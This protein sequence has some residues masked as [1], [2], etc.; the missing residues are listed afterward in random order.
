MVEVEGLDD[1][2]IYCELKDDDHCK[3]KF[4]ESPFTD[5]IGPNSR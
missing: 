1:R 5:L 2:E 3:I 4:E